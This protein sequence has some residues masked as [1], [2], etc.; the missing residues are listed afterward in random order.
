MTQHLY[1]FLSLY[2]LYYCLQVDFNPKDSNTFAS[3]S[4][5]HTIKVWGLNTSSPHFTLE[6]HQQGVNS[7]S[8]FPGG[9]K[10]Y[11]VSGSDDRTVRVWDY[12]TKACLAVLEGHQSNVSSVCFHPRLPYILSGGE[13]GALFVW[14]S[15]I[16]KRE[17]SYFL[18]MDRLWSV[19][20]LPGTNYVALGYDEGTLAIKLGNDEPVIS[21]DSTGK[22]IYAR[23]KD[24]Y[25]TRVGRTATP[26]INV[27]GGIISTNDGDPMP[28]GGELKAT[29]ESFPTSIKHSPNGRH[30][31]A[32]EGGEFVIYTAMTLTSHQQGH[33]SAVE[34][35]WN[36]TGN[37]FATRDY[38]SKVKAFKMDVKEV[39]E[40]YAFHPAYTVESIFGGQLLGVRSS[41]YIDFFDWTDRRFIR[42]IDVVPRKVYWSESGELVVLACENTYYVLRYNKD[43]VTRFAEEGVDTPDEGI[44]GA[45]VLELEV[46]E[47]VKSGS[48]MGDC[49]I[50][51]NSAKKLNYYVGGEVITLTH[52]GKPGYVLG[53]LPR[54]SKVYVVDKNYN[55]YSYTLL[56]DVLVFQAAIVRGDLP[57]A[58]AALERIPDQRTKLARFLEAR[59]LKEM[60][61]S[62]TEDPDHKFELA[63]AVGKL[64]IAH[65][66][67]VEQDVVSKWRQL[68]DAALNAFN[69]KL[70]A[71]C[72]TGA[73]D[74]ASLLLLYSSVG[75]R[76][77]LARTAQLAKEAGQHNVAFTSL[78]ALDDIAGCVDLLCSDKRAPEAA[79][80]ARTYEPSLIDKAVSQWKAQLL[81]VA[82]GGSSSSSSSSSPTSSSSKASDDVSDT[83]SSSSNAHGKASYLAVAQSL[84]S[85][86]QNKDMFPDYEFALQAE[87]AWKRYLSSASVSSLAYP[88]YANAV[89]NP[90]TSSEGSP[91]N[92]SAASGGAIT[93]IA[94]NYVAELKAGKTIGPLRFGGSQSPSTSPTSTTPPSSSSSSSVSSSSPSPTTPVVTTTAPASTASTSTPETTSPAAVSS[95]TET[96]TSPVTTPST[97]TSTT[98]SQPTTTNAPTS[99]T[100][101]PLPTTTTTPPVRPST[102]NAASSPNSPSTSST[103]TSSTAPATT[104]TP[105]SSIAPAA[106]I[107][108]TPAVTSAANTSTPTLASTTTTATTIPTPAPL[109]LT[110]PA[111]LPALNPLARPLNGAPAPLPTLPGLAPVPKPISDSTTSSTPVRPSP[112]SRTVPPTAATTTSTAAPAPL[113][114]TAPAPLPATAPAPSTATSTTSNVPATV[115]ASSAKLE[116]LT[117]KLGALDDDWDV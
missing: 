59:G 65:G 90:P 4:L 99:S 23:N 53:Y 43:L 103:P 9:D 5:D 64:D 38:G 109:P 88:M 108:P 18:G 67:A 26:A 3:A 8:Y 45:F 66:I 71:E 34:F 6:G 110:K 19:A 84:A 70:A 40:Q 56:L 94:R 7:V 87:Q 52:M 49:F 46:D 13:D 61:L 117:A 97:T 11:L 55:L 54:E 92:A 28:L 41:E 21:M 16:Y 15:G 96:K 104:T 98:T 112:L 93:S 100:S 27:P 76:T 62:V 79:L 81:A 85:P 57:A 22:V 73:K 82:S 33:G 116:E 80:L 60:A 83:K 69:L 29:W 58:Q 20:C 74:F 47:R 50:Y 86:S 89:L 106:L 101:V 77:G 25:R 30:I 95:S 72:Y 2:V 105:T 51:T 111:P 107:R 114:V 10:P 14:H 102:L 42:R 24:V 115:T 17:A 48:F 31:A 68:G 37:A 91:A 32:V 36:S 113:P 1:P 35:V 78:F 39:K 12:Q 75:H 44:E 63:L